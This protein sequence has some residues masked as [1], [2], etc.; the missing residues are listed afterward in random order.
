[1]KSVRAV[2]IASV[3]VLGAQP[4]VAQELS[5]YREYA[6]ESSVAEVVAIGGARASDARTLH[7]R[8]A[9]IQELGWRAPY[10]RSAGDPADPV[11]DVQ[12]SFCDDRLYEIVVTYERDRMAGLTDDDV[13]ES[14]SATYGVPLLSQTTTGSALP[15][16]V[17][18][19]TAVVARWEDATSLVTL[20]R[21]TYSPQYQ[22]ALVSK[23]LHARALA[24]ITEAVRLDAQEAPQRELD[25]RKKE[26]ADARSA[27]D[28]ARIVNKAAFRP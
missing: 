20:T 16:V 6:L 19:D 13:V 28:K 5:R 9:R 14:L 10:A 2:A 21:G 12:F 15:A 23:A 1:M 17:P 4:L 26:V 24:A 7:Q 27:S 22:L 18:A 25:T 11:R 3:V 8:P